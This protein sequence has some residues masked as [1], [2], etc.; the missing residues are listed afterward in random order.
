M[1]NKLITVLGLIV[2]IFGLVILSHGQEIDIKISRDK[3]GKKEVFERSYNSQ[4]ELESDDEFKEFVGDDEKFQFYFGSDDEDTKVKFFHFDDDD[5]GSG[6]KKSRF[7]YYSFGDNDFDFDF[8]TD[9]D[10]EELLEELEELKGDSKVI[11]RFHKRFDSRSSRED[12]QFEELSESESKRLIG[13]K[14][15]EG[16]SLRA[17]ADRKEFRVRAELPGTGKLTIRLLDQEENEIQS[18]TYSKISDTYLE[19]FDVRNLEEGTYFVELNF[20]GKL[21]VKKMILE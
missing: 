4:E 16:V 12:I 5:E 9:V 2:A 8:P 19:K 20:E 3:D 13:K 1:K 17:A 18:R 7:H 14:K 10:V 6:G 21:Y 15:L 11:K